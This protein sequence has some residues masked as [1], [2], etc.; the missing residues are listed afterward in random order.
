MA[1]AT[2]LSDLIGSPVRRLGGE[3]EIGSAVDF[4]IDI[5]QR[6][7][8]CALV[9]VL[10]TLHPAQTI[11][12]RE[13]L[14]LDHGTLHASASVE[15]LEA[16]RD[17]SVEQVTGLD[18]AA[19]P[20]VVVGPFGYTVAPAMAGAVL[21]AVMGR[22]KSNSG[23]RPEVERQDRNWHWFTQLFDIPVFEVTTELGKVADI[24]MEPRGLTCT[25][26]VLKTEKGDERSLDFS[27]IRNIDPNGESLIVETSPDTPYSAAS[28]AGANKRG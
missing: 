11:F 4:M 25:E 5:D 12:A 20:P 22:L 21:N 19:L 26:L 15:E 3:E 14:S 9:D 27:A 13:R 7:I 24:G 8:V 23:E 16:R 28:V 18:L 17:S 1:R 10:Q 2:R 6:T